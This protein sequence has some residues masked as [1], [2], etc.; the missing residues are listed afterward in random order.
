MSIEWTTTT[1][2]RRRLRGSALGN[3]IRAATLF[4]LCAS[5]FPACADVLENDRPYRLAPGDRIMVNVFGQLELS[6]DILVDGG[7]VIVLPF[8]GS[9]LVK[10]LTIVECQKAI[11]DRLA[12]EGVVA[13]PAVTVRVTE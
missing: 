11:T 13:H 7:G 12:A 10:D 3:W 5:A 6:G 2:A 9:L 4:C 8:I 1:A